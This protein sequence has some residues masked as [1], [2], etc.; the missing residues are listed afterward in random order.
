MAYT[1]NDYILQ[2]AIPGKA[3]PASIRDFDINNALQAKGDLL[4]ASGNPSNGAAQFGSVPIGSVGQVLA[5]SQNNLPYWTNVSSLSDEVGNGALSVNGIQLFTANQDTNS[6]LTIAAGS[7]DGAISIQVGGNTPSDIVIPGLEEPAFM[8]LQEIISYLTTTGGIAEL[9]DIP[10]VNDASFDIAF[11]GDR[12][13]SF[14]SAN[15]ASPATLSFSTGSTNG[16]INVNGNDIMVAGLGS[17]AFKDDTYFDRAGAAVGAQA[18]AEAYA[19]SLIAGLGQI[20]VIKGTTNAIP[21]STTGNETGDVW[22]VTSGDHAGEEY[23]WT[24]SAWEL[25]GSVGADGSAFIGD[26]VVT[27]GHVAVFDGTQ[28]Q[29]KDG[30]ALGDLAFADGVN[31][32]ANSFVTGISATAN[33]QTLTYVNSASKINSWT[34]GSATFSVTNGVLSLDFVA[35]TLGYDN[36]GTTTSTINVNTYSATKNSAMTLTA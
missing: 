18:A 7:T 12:A 24:G 9:S 32:P 10:T 31:V 14:F 16:A 19:D 26:N 33:N 17:A 34:A 35:P 25:L 23:V 27:D 1:G 28:G 4:V 3:N 30:G 8:T 11:N 13:N 29:L 20:M 21:T 36:A 2:V 22:I 15:A 5:V 6:S